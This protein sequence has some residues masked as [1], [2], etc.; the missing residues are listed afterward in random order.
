MHVHVICYQRAENVVLRRY[1]RENKPEELHNRETAQSRCD[2]AER[3]LLSECSLYLLKLWHMCQTKKVILC[4]PRE[5]N[6]Q[7]NILLYRIHA[8]VTTTGLG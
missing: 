6:M 3:T 4:G 2:A 1:I 5:L 8:H 7:G